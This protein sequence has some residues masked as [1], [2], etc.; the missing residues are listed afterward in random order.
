M[1]RREVEQVIRKFYD[2]DVYAIPVWSY[3][4]WRDTMV[5]KIKGNVS[6]SEI[7]KNGTPSRRGLRRKENIFPL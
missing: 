6:E 4:G 3:I 5:K 2:D 7:E 1:M